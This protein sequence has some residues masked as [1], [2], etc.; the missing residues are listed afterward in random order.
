MRLRAFKY[1]SPLIIYIGSFRAF[2]VMGWEVWMPLIYAWIII[3]G[4]ELFIRPNPGNMSAAEEELSR[5]D[6]I[7]DIFLYL[8]VVLQYA[9]LIRFLYAMSHD[10]MSWLDIIGRVWVMGMLC[11]V[12]GINVGHELGHRVSK[13]EQTLAKM[14]L[15]TSQ[16]MHF[17]VEHNKGHHKRVA[18]P[19]DPSSARHGEWIYAFYFRTIIFSYF[20]AWEI[21]INDTRKK[22]KPVLSLYNEMIRFTLIQIAFA[23]IIF[24][25]FGWLVT[26]Y[27]LAAAAIG[28]ILLETVNYIEHYGL[29]RK[30]LA[31]GKYERAMPAHSWNS[32]HVIGRLMLF[33]LSR[34]SD[35]HYLASRKY[36]VL[37]HHDDSPQMPTGYPGM[38]ILSLMPPAWFYVMNRRIRNLQKT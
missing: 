6:K 11:G 36:Q 13:F 23:A 9:A 8:V 16:Y 2:T 31:D 17:F 4:L 14:L 5:N 19:E 10:Q 28:I 21:A 27:Y 18:T 22:G 20:S 3:P 37:R 35:H 33:E 12:F 1:L 38:M 26:L 32:D 24:F 30:Q 7:Y 25:V 15:L 29:Q 34:H